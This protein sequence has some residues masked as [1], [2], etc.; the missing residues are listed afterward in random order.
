VAEVESLPLS[1]SDL[2]F[3]V[4]YDLSRFVVVAGQN[5]YELR[6]P[7]LFW[8]V[9]EIELHRLVQAH[10][11]ELNRLAG[12]PADTVAAHA[13][14]NEQIVELLHQEGIVEYERS[15]IADDH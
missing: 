11:R 7:G 10:H 3:A 15:E 5:R 1:P 6:R 14:R 13:F 9:D 8:P 4:T 2:L 12:I